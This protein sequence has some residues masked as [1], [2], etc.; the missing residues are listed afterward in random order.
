[1]AYSVEI[2][3]PEQGV[4][5]TSSGIGLLAKSKY[6]NINSMDTLLIAGGIGYE[7]L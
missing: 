2:V 6:S 5:E 3:A 1:L 7:A 4:L